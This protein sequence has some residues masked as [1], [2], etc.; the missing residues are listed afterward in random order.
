MA[1]W[2]TG[3]PPKKKGI[4]LVTHETCFGRSVRVA[5]RVEYPKGH[6]YWSLLPS[7]AVM[8]KDIV[9][10]QKCPEPY[11]GQ[12]E[13]MER[14]TKNERNCNGS[15]ISKE[16]LLSY[17]SYNAYLNEYASKIL[18]KLDDYEDAEEEGR[19][20]ILPCAIG[21]PIF[22]V[23]KVNIYNGLGD[24][25]ES[26]IRLEESKFSLEWC[27]RLE[28]FGKNI[29]TTREAAEQKKAE[30]ERAEDVRK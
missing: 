8:D 25:L 1:E 13:S 19:L 26:E 10:W 22:E 28:D 3:E 21:T 2:Q 4:Y 17:T 12:E 11:R 24:F 30:L 23:Y 16:S 29:F 6:W 9:A 7:G 5:D 27:G 18:T 14:L 20:I 15:G